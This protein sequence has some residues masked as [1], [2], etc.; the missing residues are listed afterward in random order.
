M[1][2]KNI[3]EQIE[4]DMTWVN[5]LCEVYGCYTVEALNILKYHDEVLIRLEN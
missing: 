4:F 3:D 2:S 1:T 5:K